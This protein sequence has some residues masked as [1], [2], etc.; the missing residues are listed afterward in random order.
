MSCRTSQFEMC[1]NRGCA[2]END[3][4]R[5]TCCERECNNQKV[6]AGH[7]KNIVMCVNYCLQRMTGES[8]EIVMRE[9]ELSKIRA[10]KVKE[11]LTVQD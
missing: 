9:N 11:S 10:E 3:Q 7:L 1:L 2:V 8:Y 6:I 4:A 5:K